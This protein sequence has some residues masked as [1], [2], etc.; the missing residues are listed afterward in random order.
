MNTPTRRDAAIDEIATTLEVAPAP[1]RETEE[2]R[3]IK[4]KLI[5][6]R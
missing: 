6:R 3:R 1:V 4:S 5:G 2:F